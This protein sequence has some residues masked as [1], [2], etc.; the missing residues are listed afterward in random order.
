MAK[1]STN[2]TALYHQF[3]KELRSGSPRPVYFFCGEESFYSDALQEEIEAL[4]PVDLRDFNMDILYG[5]EQSLDKI[6]GIV[7][8]YPMMAD[9]RIVILREFSGL[10]SPVRR[11]DS[12][13]EGEGDPVEESIPA[14]TEM[15]IGY[16]LKPNPSTVLAIIDQKPPNAGTKLGK[17]IIKNEAVGYANF[18]PI[19]EERLPEWIVEWVQTTHNRQIKPQAAQVMAR[20][21][22]SDLTL[23]SKELDK[24]CTFKDNGE[25][26][27]EADVKKL[28]TPSREYSVFELKEALFTKNVTQTL[29]VAEQMLHTS[30]TTDVGEVIRIVSFFY[31]V[32]TNI[33]QI[34]RLTQKGLPAAQIRSTIG[35]KSEWYF[36]NLVRDSRVF[37]YESMPLIFEALLD[38]DRAVK[39]MSRMEAEDIV[40]LM[41]RRILG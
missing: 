15:L 19:P 13:E 35:V 37:P 4:L 18:D 2:S 39:G 26:I 27:N 41:F 36:N 17:A 33:W 16:L 32:F 34:Q 3:V 8:S 14:S 9:R 23:V 6:L 29:W 10:F 22:G 24:L 20:L 12:N 7:R 1:S 30:K 21:T 25:A 40:F 28:V 11:T 5:T 38:A 31:S